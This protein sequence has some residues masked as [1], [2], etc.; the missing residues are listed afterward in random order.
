MPYT[1][2]FIKFIT[3]GYKKIE[4][5]EK[6]NISLLP[7]RDYG[8]FIV[9]FSRL[10]FSRLG[11]GTKEPMGRCRTVPSWVWEKCYYVG[12]FY[13]INRMSPTLGIMGG[14]DW[15]RRYPAGQ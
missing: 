3:K 9:L 2:Y 1:G 10:F 5:L 12:L 8:G 15:K 7:V 14:P 13:R 11:F 4:K 6:N